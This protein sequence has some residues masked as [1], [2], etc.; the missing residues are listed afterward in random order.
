MKVRNKSVTV[1]AA[2]AAAGRQNSPHISLSD[3][4][5][6]ILGAAVSVSHTGGPGYAQK[7]HITYREELGDGTLLHQ[8]LGSGYVA[9]DSP[10]CLSYHPI[11]KGPGEIFA[12]VNQ[13][14]ANICELQITYRRE[15][16]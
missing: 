13:A 5:W 4:P 7:C 6:E 15:Q 3:G 10:F 9:P 12:I 1:T 14:E 16:E 2:A 8:N 11:V